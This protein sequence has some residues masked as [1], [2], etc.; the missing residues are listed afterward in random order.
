MKASDITDD[1][2]RAALDPDGAW[3]HWDTVT[4]RLGYPPRVVLA[5]AR[6]LIDRRGTVHGCPCGCRGDFHWAEECRG[7]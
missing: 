3:T 7:C 4:E 1:E 5:K 2:F 6:T